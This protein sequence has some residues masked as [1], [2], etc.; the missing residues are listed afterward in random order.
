MDKRCWICRRTEKEVIADDYS[1]ITVDKKQ[2]VI[3]PIKEPSSVHS[4]QICDVCKVYIEII[5]WNMFIAQRDTID[6][7]SPVLMKD[8]WDFSD[9]LKKA[10]E[11]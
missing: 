10:L 7:L 1:S 5:S 3:N 2:N 9:K 8:M 6:E 4:I 11:E